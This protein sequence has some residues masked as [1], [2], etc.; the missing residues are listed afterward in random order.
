MPSLT[1]CRTAGRP[2]VTDTR[3]RTTVFDCARARII[4]G[5]TVAD[6]AKAY[7]VSDRTVIRWTQAAL[8]DPG[9]EGDALR[10]LLKASGRRAS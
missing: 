6:A 8:D 5:V 2:R 1:V 4:N 3:L 9:R 7:G 10:R